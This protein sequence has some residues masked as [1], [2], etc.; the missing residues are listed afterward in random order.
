MLV[1]IHL[2]AKAEGGARASSAP[3]PPPPDRV[4]DGRGGRDDR[5]RMPLKASGEPLRLRACRPVASL[6]AASGLQRAAFLPGSGGGAG[7]G[8]QASPEAFRPPG[9]SVAP[10]RLLVQQFQAT[11]TI[12]CI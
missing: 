5:T 8:G 10:A 2:F 4:R 11:Q 1:C 3:S 9:R 12:Y 6:V 7:L